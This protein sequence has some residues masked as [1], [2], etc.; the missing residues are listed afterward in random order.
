[1]TAIMPTYKRFEVTFE[2]GEGARLYDVNGKEYIDALC[3]LAVTGLGHAHPR[4]TAALTRQ[5]GRLL[6]T[7]NLYGI[8]QQERLAERLTTLSGM[9]NVFFGN[10][11]AEA[12]EA[13]I[14][15]ARLY[16]HSKGIATPGIVVVDNSFHGRTMATLTA[17]GNRKVQA[18]FEPLL[19]G[20]V[21]A[22]FNDM[23]TM[24]NIAANDKNVVA[25]MVEPILGEGG[26]QIPDEDYLPAL[27]ALCDENGWL[28]M[29]DEIQTG[30][31]RSG[32]FFCYQH[33]GILPDVVTLAKGL[34]NGVPIGVCLARGAAAGMLIA[35][36]HGSTF[37]GNPLVC[38]AGN[39]VLD[40]L[41][42]GLIERAGELGERMLAGLRKGLQ[43]NNRVKDIRGKGL[44]LAVELHQPCTQIAQQAMDA[45]VLLNVTL[46]T[47]VRL[48][49]PLILS[50]EDADTV[51]ATVV[52][53]V[54]A[55][56]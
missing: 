28:L 30:S 22:P 4:V 40:E 35:G 32:K 7:S 37:G 33:T 12:N 27:R 20:F 45:G 5:A 41:E 17:T 39:A 19:G 26:I 25:V 43:G 36:T 3:G 51:V 16:G 47:I 10:S 56:E 18:G 2:R 48:L 53:L 21:R 6:H 15:I 52:D 9:D 11:G 34:G 14:K 54:N 46:D 50:N 49:P 31:G 55:L 13:A 23:A 44:L 38:A 24:R 29:L 42:G 8:G 1:M